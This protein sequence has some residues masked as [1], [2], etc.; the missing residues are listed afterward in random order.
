MSVLNKFGMFAKTLTQKGRDGLMFTTYTSDH[1]LF[2]LIGC[3]VHISTDFDNA[4]RDRA[5]VNCYNVRDM[6][7]NKSCVMCLLP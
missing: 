7:S 2:F 3:M 4:R 1:P 6:I 5:C